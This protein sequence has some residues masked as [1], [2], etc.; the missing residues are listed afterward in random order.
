MHDWGKAELV[1][2]IKLL[3][4]QDLTMVSK[5]LIGGDCEGMVK[6][7]YNADLELGV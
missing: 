1:H 4:V 7:I 6:E 2:Q 5:F 3:G